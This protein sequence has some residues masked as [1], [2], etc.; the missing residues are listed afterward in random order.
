MKKID[1]K[2]II[3]ELSKNLD[4][5]KYIVMEEKK[6]LQEEMNK[7]KTE[8]LNIE[9][10]I[11]KQTEVQETVTTEQIVEENQSEEVKNQQDIPQDSEKTEDEKTDVPREEIQKEEIQGEELPDEAESQEV[12]SEEQISEENE[13]DKEKKEKRKKKKQP[14]FYED[15]LLKNNWKQKR[16]R[17]I[18]WGGVELDE[19]VQKL[20]SYIPENFQGRLLDVPAGTGVFT[21]EKYAQLNEAKIVCLEPREKEAE[22]LKEVLGQDENCSHVKVIDGKIGRLPFRRER[23]DVVLCMNGFQAFQNKSRAFSEVTRVL[24]KRG[25]LIGCFYVKGQSKKADWFVKHVYA[26]KGWFAPPYDTLSSLRLKL[27]ADY[28][29]KSFHVRGSMVYFCAVKKD[30]LAIVHTRENHFA[31]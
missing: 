2:I 12:Q 7:Q 30:N 21:H 1:K 28:R 13:K 11:Q 10:Q 6:Q 19:V 8:E 15:F 22:Q 3:I 20:L 4:S 18:L 27:A 23:F 29:I 9:K 16:Y 17:K 25:R 31:D 14:V 5:G 26:K 24:R